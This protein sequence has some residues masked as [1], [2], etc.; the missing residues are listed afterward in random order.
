[1]VLKLLRV[2]RTICSPDVFIKASQYKID[3]KLSTLDK[4]GYPIVTI[5]VTI[6]NIKLV[7]SN[8]T[9][10]DTRADQAGSNRLRFT[11]T[12]QKDF[13]TRAKRSPDI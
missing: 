2:S 3:A 13:T 1:M 12:G 5:I 8:L 11:S 10:N 9:W 4:G 6:V 7:V